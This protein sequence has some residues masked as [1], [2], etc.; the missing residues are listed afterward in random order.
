MHFIQKLKQFRQSRLDARFVQAHQASLADLKNNDL[1]SAMDRMDIWSKKGYAE[2]TLSLRTILFYH[3]V[4]SADD[5]QDK[6]HYMTAANNLLRLAADQGD[7]NSQYLVGNMYEFG[8]GYDTDPAL[9]FTYYQM[10]AIQG[11]PKA[12][13]N[14]GRCY[15]NGFGTERDFKNAVFWF[16][17][18]AANGNP[19]AQLNMGYQYQ[20]GKGVNTD[21]E[22]AQ[23]WFETSMNT[24]NRIL[25]DTCHHAA[26]VINSV[27]ETFE[28]AAAALK[29][30]Q[31]QKKFSE[32]SSITDTRKNA[33]AGNWRAQFELGLMYDIGKDL[34]Q[35]F[36]EAMKWYTL[37]ANNG[38]AGAMHNIG[39]LY[40]NGSG[41]QKSYE[42]AY[43]W[44]MRA[45]DASEYKHSLEMIGWMYE[46]GY[47]VEQ[48]YE[49]AVQ[50][51]EKAAA[52]DQYEALYSL[53]VLTETGRGTKQDLTKAISLYKRSASQGYKRAQ[54]R[55]DALN[56]EEIDAETK[57]KTEFLN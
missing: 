32:I 53:G 12:Q 22:K 25:H 6:L 21:L 27:K 16:E 42:T 3:A 39:I 40:L 49:K 35:N 55:L 50:W 8:D 56:A 37:A 20:N 4:S 28:E 18:S 48:S 51:Y 54:K 57:Q 26:P 24:C 5:P 9:A 29:I 34:P 36:E 30:L 19:K 46:H 1:K 2:A 43:K 41:V 11:H 23:Q 47:Y 44:L 33:E 45:I 38:S 31:T 14:L 7:V 17:K 52:Q 13:N 15:L 10:A